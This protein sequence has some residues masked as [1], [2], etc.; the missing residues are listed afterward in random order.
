MPLYVRLLD[1]ITTSQVT[2]F[3]TALLYIFVVIG[4]L[5]RRASA[6]F[7][8]IA[9]NV[10]PIVFTLGFM[11]LF[12]IRLDIATV[13][14]A[15]I[16]LG[17]A[18][19]DTIHE[20]FR[21]YQFLDTGLSPRDAIRRCLDMEGTAVICASII[22]CLGFA[23]LGLASIKSVVYFGLLISLTMIFAFLGE[24]YMLPAMI[25]RLYPDP[26]RARGGRGA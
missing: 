25:T 13:T 6:L 8:G 24:L 9:P 16:T 21:F 17:I 5:F 7:L 10:V 23:I 3:A 11:G 20:L 4:L 26:H 18:V 15:S 2:S 1:Y 19:D 12:G 22:L 14:I